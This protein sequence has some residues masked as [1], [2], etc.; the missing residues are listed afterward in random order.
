MLD[1]LKVLRDDWQEVAAIQA[2]WIG[3]CDVFRFTLPVH[4]CFSF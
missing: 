2:N 3:K 4:V 1:G